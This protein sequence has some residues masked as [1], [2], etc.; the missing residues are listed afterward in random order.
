MTYIEI[1]D[2]AVALDSIWVQDDAVVEGDGR[3][4]Q[5]PVLEV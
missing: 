5:V 3:E 2:E 4:G 1:I